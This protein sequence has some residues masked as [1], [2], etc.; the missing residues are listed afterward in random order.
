MVR[1]QYNREA[2][3][4]REGSKIKFRCK[5]KLSMA[6]D[7]KGSAEQKGTAQFQV[8][9]ATLLLN[10]SALRHAQVGR[11][12]GTNRDQIRW[13]MIAL[14]RFRDRPTSASK[15]D[16]Q[17]NDQRLTPS[18]PTHPPTQM[19]TEHCEIGESGGGD[20]A[21][22]GEEGAGA[23]AGRGGDGHAGTADLFQGGHH[24]GRGWRRGM[25][26]G[27]DDLGDPKPIQRINR[28][29]AL[30]PSKMSLSNLNGSY[31]VDELLRKMRRVRRQR[32][33]DLWRGEGIGV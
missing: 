10:V 9:E 26:M 17:V 23:G 16:R 3:D 13:S 29:F 28:R 22:G 7:G 24:H 4:C 32:L 25:G 12:K 8:S 18:S 20:E 11:G 5:T 30:L 1:E 33:A 19:P 27:A 6:M 15:G 14:T 2:K 21:G 31:I